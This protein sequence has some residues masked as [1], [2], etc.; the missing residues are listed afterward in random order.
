MA[1]RMS[2]RERIERLAAEKVATD[3]EKTDKK[4]KKKVAKTASKS[5]TSRKKVTK[6]TKREKTVWKVYNSN[7]KEMACFPYPKK[8]AA[9]T[10][11]KKLTKKTGNQHFVNS[12]KVPMEDDE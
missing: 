1:R 4:K 7:F 8:A 9:E 3:R 10:E 5:T 2:N 11:A 12:A 6:T